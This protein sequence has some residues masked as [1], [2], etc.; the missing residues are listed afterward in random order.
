[1]ERKIDGNLLRWKNSRSRRP[2]LLKGAR[3]V[4]KTWS[5][6]SFGKK[7][8]KNILYLNFESNVELQ[9][10]FER[11]LAPARIL[12]ELSALTGQTIM[13]TDS[14]IIF[15]EIQACERAL[16]SLKYFYEEAP[17]YH[18]A[19]AG[20]LLGVAINRKKYSFPVGKVDFLNMYPFDFEEFMLAT[21][22]DKAIS[23]IR[24]CYRQNQPCALH[25]TFLDA[26][27]RYL[28][29]GGMP[30]V[31]KEF[32]ETGD[33]NLMVAIQ[34]NINDAYIADM[35]KYASPQETVRIMA[36]FNS[37]PAQLAKEN[38]KFQYST[39]KSGARALHY[40]SA[41]DWL[42]AAGII[43]KCMKVTSG[44]FPI[45][46]WAEQSS[47]KAY[48][49]DT[50]LLCSK[51]GIPPSAISNEIRGYESIKGA[52][53]ENYVANT[54]KTN[55]FTP[56]Y[57]ESRGKAE[58]DFLIQNHSGE[59]IPIEVKSSKHVRSK[60]LQQFISNYNPSWSMRISAK[61]FGFENN[62]K[63]VPLYAVFCIAL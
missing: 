42:E 34:K 52:L 61:N 49:N 10:I 9:G 46:I 31:V 41:I 2:L 55:G 32:I 4:G 12:N 37:I 58:I 28:Y 1:M 24:D 3:Q 33:H 43:A 57:W 48:M 45:A 51:F 60:S 29:I 50:G 47:F 22:Q 30:Q 44:T 35:A 25:Q 56:Y 16:T 26:Y 18:I 6:L 63:S 62:I 20:S 36:A 13:Q 21:G 17:E 14:L 7:H 15:D 38:R 23:M 19:A 27:S 8:Y 59:V 53:S 39:I 5:L 54:L 40:E 11:D